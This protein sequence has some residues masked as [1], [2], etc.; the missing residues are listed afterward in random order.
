M[1]SARACWFEFAMSLVWLT[2]ALVS[3]ATAAARGRWLIVGLQAVM[4]GAFVYLAVGWWKL[5][6]EAQRGMRR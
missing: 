6:R 4:S 2:V 1:R 3:L 5:A